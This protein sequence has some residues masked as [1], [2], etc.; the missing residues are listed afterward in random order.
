MVLPS[1]AGARRSAAA[2]SAAADAEALGAP[3]GPAVAVA[4]VA[5]E[6]E[7]PVGL[8]GPASSP[9]WQAAS[10]AV[11]HRIRV[12]RI[13]LGT[14]PTGTSGG[15]ETMRDGAQPRAPAQNT[16]NPHSPR[17]NAASSPGTWCC[18]F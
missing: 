7:V 5:V 12:R 9:P 3:I 8:V 6:A 18:A 17:T 1:W 14:I 15:W 13:Q 11:M 16:R 10:A 2:G 4:D